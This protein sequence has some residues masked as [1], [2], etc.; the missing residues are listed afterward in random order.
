MKKLYSKIKRRLKKLASF[1]FPFNTHLRPSHVFLL[2][3]DKKIT[4][5]NQDVIPHF[6]YPKL[7]TKLTIANDLYEACSTYWKPKRQAV[8]DYVVVEVPGGR[9]HTDNESSVA[10]I[11]RCNH[12]IEN[13]SLSLRH[14]KVTDSGF[15][16]IFEQ[17]YFTK[18]VQFKG[19]VFSMLTGGAG[20]NN[21]SHWFLDVLPRLHLLQ[22]SGLY[23]EVDWFL[24]PSLQYNYQ[25]ETLHILGIPQEKIIAGDVYPHIT[26]DKIIASTAPRGNHTLVPAWL[27]DYVREAILPLAH[28]H[29]TTIELTPKIYISRSDSRYR[30]VT[31]EAG[32]VA[33]LQQ[34]GYKSFVLSE[35]S[36]IEKIKLFSNAESVI[37]ATGAGLVNLLFC[38][39]GTNVIEIFNEGFVVEPFYDIAARTELDYNYIICKG[40]DVNNVGQGQRENL[41]VDIDRVIEMLRN[42]KKDLKLKQIA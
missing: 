8:T 9:I 19:T 10:I 29:V 37:S 27:C 13:V 15:N 2:D 11:N 38:K 3:S 7:V 33:E 17:R 39:P 32:L 40:R 23:N 25:V 24:V 6:I 16:P 36:T 18:P 22:K 31:N 35:L 21:I 4:E 28:D 30:C 34:Y 20:L 5:P 41:T 14:S 26:A 12:L 42:G 1:I